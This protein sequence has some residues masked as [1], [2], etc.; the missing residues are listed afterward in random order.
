MIAPGPMA[1]GELMRGEHS[2]DLAPLGLLA[3]IL[4]VAVGNVLVCTAVKLEKRLHRMTFYF[5]VSMAVA[6]IL[7]AGTAMPPAVLVVLAGKF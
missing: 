1:P 6:H 7:M 4:V 3:I 5:F 2:E